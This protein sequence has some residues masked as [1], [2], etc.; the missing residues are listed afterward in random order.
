MVTEKL[1]N[2][3]STPTAID[4]W[5]MYPL[6]QLYLLSPLIRKITNN[7]GR[8]FVIYVVGLWPVSSSLLPTI[9]AFLPKA[10]RPLVT[11]DGRYNHEDVDAS[12]RVARI[13]LC[14][15]RP[16]LEPCRE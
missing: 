14:E 7:A 9:A 13:H 3:P 1:K 2:F 16:I 12:G 6:I 10:Y 4:L 8:S 5:F 15:Y 11:L